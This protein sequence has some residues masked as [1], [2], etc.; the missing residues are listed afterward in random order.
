M[1]KETIQI[2]DKRHYKNFDITN[3]ID[4]SIKSSFLF[5]PEDDIKSRIG[6]SGSEL[7]QLYDKIKKLL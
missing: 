6:I 3:D 4:F 2:L 1:A 5:S 7:I